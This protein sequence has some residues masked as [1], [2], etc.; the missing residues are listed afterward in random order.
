MTQIICIVQI[1][2]LIYKCELCPILHA[3]LLH[4]TLNQHTHKFIAH[5]LA[6]DKQVYSHLIISAEDLLHLTES[7]LANRCITNLACLFQLVWSL[8][9]ICCFQDP[10]D[11]VEA[12]QGPRGIITQNQIR[13][14]SGSAVTSENVNIARCTAGRCS[15]TFEPPS[16]PPSSYDS[17]SVAA[18]SVVG[19]GA[20]TKCT[21]QSISEWRCYNMLLVGKHRSLWCQVCMSIS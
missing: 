5:S 8:F 12:C 1:H 7:A 17:V 11:P 19:L 18:E 15:Y 16:N 2:Q 4:F 14:Q 20:A 13:F 9:L 3:L 10:L 6:N 21:A